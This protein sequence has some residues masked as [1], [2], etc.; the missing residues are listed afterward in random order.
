MPLFVI[1]LSGISVRTHCLTAHCLV[2]YG[3]FFLLHFFGGSAYPCLFFVELV[4]LLS[5]A[6]NSKR[7][8]IGYFYMFMYREC[9][10]NHYLSVFFRLLYTF[11]QYCRIIVISL[12]LTKEII[13][14]KYLF[15]WLV[16]HHPCLQNVWSHTFV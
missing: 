7:T 15:Q 8:T 1:I 16:I 2:L 3:S 10:S 11:H 14:V 4:L 6:A 12:F 13:N 5:W 9:K